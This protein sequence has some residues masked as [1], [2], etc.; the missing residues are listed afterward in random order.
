MK[1]NWIIYSIA[2]LIALS[3]FI[4]ANSATA[5]AA[6]L[7]IVSSPL[8]SVAVGRFN[9]SRT[10]LRLSLQEA[11]GA[12]QDAELSIDVRRAPLFR[13]KIELELEARNLVHGTTWKIPVTLAP[14][15]SKQEHFALPLRT[16]NCGRVSL[17]LTK[18]AAL[19]NL[20]FMHCPLTCDF[21]E[22]YTVYPR[23]YDLKILIARTNH[24]SASGI[25]FD[26]TRRGQDKTEVFDLRGY[27]DG[28]TL[29]SVHWKLSARTDDL[30]VREASHPADYDIAIIFG[31]CNCD[32][33]D[34]A[35]TEVLNAA[36]SLLASVSAALLRQGAGHRV[37]YSNED[38]LAVETID[39]TAS[40]N[41]MLDTIMAAPLPTDR[42]ADAHAFR[43]MRRANA[44][45]K[46]IVIT[47]EIPSTMAQAIAKNTALT[48]LHI[49]AEALDVRKEDDWLLVNVPLADVGST[50][51]NL[52]L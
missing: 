40:F 41:D 31:M 29:K 37:I 5:L 44:I 6:C 46:A 2:L 10:A 15:S 7:L 47:D 36:F 51:K 50:I 24:A 34:R 39:G 32:A 20:G 35:Q 30:M 3:A 17:K 45:T 4:A 49:G 19:D 1:R 8:A 21:E 42:F 9:A 43:E 52:E 28:D 18:A 26:P 13:G 11:C 12:D 22:D 48:I 14:S 23:I 27:R 25:E 33:D 16:S 38:L